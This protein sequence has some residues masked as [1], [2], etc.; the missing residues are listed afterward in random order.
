MKLAKPSIEERE[1]RRDAAYERG[2]VDS[3]KA[4]WNQSRQSFDDIY[5]Y[6]EGWQACADYRWAD[7]KNLGRAP[8]PNFR[9][10]RTRNA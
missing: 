3:L 10:P 7:R 4:H 8:D 5:Y 9:T 1:A 6:A 2:W